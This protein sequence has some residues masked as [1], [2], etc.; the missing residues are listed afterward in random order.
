MRIFDRR[1]IKKDRML[2]FKI[3]PKM[4]KKTGILVVGG[5]SGMDGI[6]EQYI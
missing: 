4:C 1:D 6:C 2:G 3:R 5:M